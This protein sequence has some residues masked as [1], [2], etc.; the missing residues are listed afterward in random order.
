MA[1][2]LNHFLAIYIGNEDQNAGRVEARA[3]DMLRYDRCHPL[4]S[5][6]RFQALG[7][8]ILIQPYVKDMRGGFTLARWV[9]HGFKTLF[10]AKAESRHVPLELEDM[11]L[12]FVKRKEGP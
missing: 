1:R 2:A 10:E 3:W 5:Q 11:I 4:G 9:S 7:F 6:D 12:A 8:L